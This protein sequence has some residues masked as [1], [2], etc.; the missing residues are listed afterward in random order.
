MLLVSKVKEAKKKNRKNRGF[1]KVT[2]DGADR[3]ERWCVDT[4]DK[5]IL[6]YEKDREIYSDDEEDPATVKEEDVEEVVD[7]VAA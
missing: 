7:E 4:N 5:E 1:G 3:D 6:A 2:E